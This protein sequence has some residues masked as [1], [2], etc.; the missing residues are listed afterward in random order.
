MILIDNNLQRTD[1]NRRQSQGLEQILA[2]FEH[3]DARP[4]QN[5]I[6][7]KSCFEAR[8]PGSN[9]HKTAPAAGKTPTL[10]RTLPYL[11]LNSIVS[12]ALQRIEY[13]YE[14]RMAHNHQSKSELAFT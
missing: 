12:R 3:S 10:S 2:K 6:R 13:A 14:S 8:R 5:T 7:I 11:S 1:V 9:P 4:G